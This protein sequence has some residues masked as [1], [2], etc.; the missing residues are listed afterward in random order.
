MKVIDIDKGSYGESVNF[1]DDNNLL[2]GYDMSS[3]CCENFGWYISYD[4]DDYGLDNKFSNDHWENYSFVN[5]EP[6]ILDFSSGDWGEPDSRA[7]F[8]MMDN[9]GNFTYLFLFNI[10]NG[11]YSHGFSFHDNGQVIHYGSL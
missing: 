3:D 9:H 1:V 7:R 5:E 4:P 6:T 11:Y 10:H 2:V 8:R